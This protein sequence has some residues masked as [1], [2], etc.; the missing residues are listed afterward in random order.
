MD[1][2][3]EI[4]AMRLE[5]LEKEL[6]IAEMEK[7]MEIE[8]LNGMKEVNSLEKEI[9][10]LNQE[11]KDPKTGLSKSLMVRYQGKFKELDN[12][13]AKLQKEIEDIKSRLSSLN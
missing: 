3:A 2:Q 5:V 13:I 9:N 10:S 11:E 1:K 12:R 4:A 6:K 8:Y 7:N